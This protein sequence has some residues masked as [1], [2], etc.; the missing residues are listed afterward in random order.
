MQ[1]IE[2]YLTHGISR[3]ILGTSALQNK[4]LLKKALERYHD[5]IAVGIDARDGQVMVEGWLDGSGM[6]YLDFAREMEDM[7]VSNIIFTDISRD[8]TLSGPALELLSVLQNEL[9]MDITA[10]GGIHTIEDITQLRDLGLY[11]A[12]TGKAV[13]AGTLD[14]QEAI[15]RGKTC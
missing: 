3:V 11:G 13:Y 6:N 10:S 4:D 12:I 8:G 2:W 7:G 5:Q 1:D 9:H 14:L 15:E